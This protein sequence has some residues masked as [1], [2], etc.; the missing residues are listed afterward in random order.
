[1]EY[2]YYIQTKWSV[3]VVFQK[4]VLISVYEVYRVRNRLAFI[5]AVV[6][7]RIS[8]RIECR[9]EPAHGSLIFL[10]QISTREAV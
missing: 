8:A 7:S 9:L 3:I 2:D 4:I 6:R 5:K 10:C 1:M